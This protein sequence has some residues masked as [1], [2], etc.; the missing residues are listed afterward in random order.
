LL[1]SKIKPSCLC[2][3]ILFCAIG[4]LFL[5][6]MVSAADLLQAGMKLHAKYTDDEFYPAEVV[7][8]ATGK[9]RAKAPVKVHYIGYET[10]DDAWLS[11]D[12]L[13]SKKIPKAAAAV[14]TPTAKAKATVKAK[15]KP[16]KPEG[17]VKTH[18]KAIM[19]AAQSFTL[20]KG[21]LKVRPIEKDDM[22]KAAEICQEAFNTFNASVGLDPEFP[23]VEVVNVPEFLLGQAFTDGFK[24][25][26]CTNKG[27][28]VGSNLIE[29]RDGIGGIGPISVSTNGQ[30]TGA[31]RLLMQACMKAAA[32]AGI[33]SV[34]LHG[35]ASNKKSVSLYLDSGFDPVCT[36]G[37]YEGFCT[38]EA[39]EGYTSKPLSVEVVDE[40]SKLHRK[41]NGSQ[42][43]KDIASMIGCPHP[44]CVVMDSK[45]KVVAYTT[46]SFLS[47][48]TVADSED[49]LKA[50]IVAQSKAIKA[51]QDAGAPIPPTTVFVPHAYA[52]VTRWL[53]RNGFRLNRQVI[54]M[55]YGPHRQPRRGFYFPAIQY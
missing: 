44:N 22:N 48:H 50:L 13:K 37:H 35:I 14:P 8:V 45:G 51:A 21:D 7:T 43:S 23:P 54:Q 11:L 24:G 34:R 29:L 26:V 9:K 2:N 28:V 5:A 30:N 18:G 46:G 16:A 47:G 12:A 41:I 4:H 15:A 39:P 27:E 42:R 3:Y 38:A 10:S 33:E 19:E 49:A 25:F 52:E 31:G 20:E 55:S 32:D 36:C 6:I 17:Y 40:C 53:C 1:K